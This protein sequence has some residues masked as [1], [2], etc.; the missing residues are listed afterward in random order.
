MTWQCE[1]QGLSMTLSREVPVRISRALH[2]YLTRLCES[3]GVDLQAALKKGFFAI[4]PGG[5]KIL[6]QIQDLLQ[7]EPSQIQHSVDVLKL[8]GNMSSATLPHIWQRMLE[9]PTIP[10]QGLIISLALGLD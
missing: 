7:L 2:G 10:N 9:D 8:Y 5:P 1:D 6:Q 3:A 4:H